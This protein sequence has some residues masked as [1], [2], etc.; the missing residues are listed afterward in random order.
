MGFGLEEEDGVLFTPMTLPHT[1]EAGRKISAETG[2][3]NDML[4]FDDIGSCVYTQFIIMHTMRYSRNLS[5]WNKR[6]LYPDMGVEVSLCVPFTKSMIE[7][8]YIMMVANIIGI[9]FI[10]SYTFGLYSVTM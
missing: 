2:G 10:L 5:D 4:P 6:F 8:Y 9:L 1:L 7:C 3:L